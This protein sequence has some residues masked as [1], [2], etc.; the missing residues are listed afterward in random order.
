MSAFKRNTAGNR[1]RGFAAAQ[2]GALLLENGLAGEP[3]T[4]A[5]DGKHLDQHLITFFE[6]IVY[7]G[8]A[9][10][11]HF[12][13]VQQAIGAGEYLHEGA[14][15]RQPDDFAKI[16]LAYFGNS[17]EIANHLQGPGGCFLVV[18][19]DVDL[20]AIIH[21]NLDAGSVNDAANDFAAGTDEV[22][23]LIHG[24]L[25]GMDAG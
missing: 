7:I 11:G 25:Q 21:V 16:G 14:E 4:V 13:D 9:V 19:G 3:D 22:T 15:F 5:F 10:L 8:N 24:N 20:A 1:H 6:L 12:T 17:G 23:D 2:P 18:R